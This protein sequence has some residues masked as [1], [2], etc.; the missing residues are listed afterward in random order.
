M[1][2]VDG[3]NPQSKF[4]GAWA[5]RRTAI[6]FVSTINSWPRAEYGTSLRGHAYY[7]L[8]RILR[9]GTS[10]HIAV[11]SEIEQALLA[12][13]VPPSRVVHIPAAIDTQTDSLPVSRLE[14][15]RELG[16]GPEMPLCCAV[17]RLATAKGFIHLIDAMGEL[18]RDSADICCLIVGEGPLRESLQS[19]AD[20]LGLANRVRFLGFRPRADALAILAASDLFVMPSLTEGTPVAILE[21][22]FLKRPIVASRVGGIPSLLTDGEHA[23]LVPPGDSHRLAQAISDLSQR[24][25]HARA[26]GLRAHQHVRTHFDLRR[27][28]ESTLQAY[29]QAVVHNGRRPQVVS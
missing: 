4:W 8:E 3:Q 6:A 23:V 22:A 16:I 17:G 12:D 21:A 27:Q 19:R 7:L 13:G 5:A 1:Q 18:V 26:M 10:L 24:R 25:D 28:V 9:R 14:I 2:V 29:R 20:E 15:R 11:S